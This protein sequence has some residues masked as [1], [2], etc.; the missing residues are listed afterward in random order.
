[1]QSYRLEVAVKRVY[2]L[3]PLI[4]SASST[5][6]VEVRFLDFPPIVIHPHGYAIG[7]SVTYNICHKADFRM[8]SEQA[9]TAFPA[10]CQCQLVSAKEGTVVGAARW[11]CPC[12]LVSQPD[13]AAQPPLRT[14]ADY[15]IGNAAGETVGYADMNCRVLSL[16]APAPQASV[17]PLPVAAPPARDPE[18][19]RGTSAD[20]G[21]PY[22]VRV[23]VGESDRHRRPSQ[24]TRCEGV[25]DASRG[26]EVTAARA[27]TSD[28]G[29]PPR[30]VPANTAEKSSLLYLLQ[31]DVAYQLQSLSETVAAALH[32][33][34]DVLTRT[35]LKGPDK[36]GTVSTSRLTKSI[37]HHV[38][39]IV[40]VANI[41]LQVANQLVDNSPAPPRIGTSREVKDMVRQWRNPVNKLPLPAEGSIGHYLQYDV[42]YQLQCLGTNL[43]YMIVAYRAAL[44]I[45]LSS[46]PAQHVEYCDEL[47]HEIQHLTKHINILIQSS[48]D[49]TLSTAAPSIVPEPVAQDKHRKRSKRNSQSTPPAAGP[50]LAPPKFTGVAKSLSRT[51]YSSFS[52][53]RSASS[54][55][56]SS[57]SSSSSLN[58]PPARASP[59]QA[60]TVVAVPAN[61]PPAVP[62]PQAAAPMPNATS[63]PVPPPPSYN[64]PAAT[65]SSPQTSPPLATPPP[66]PYTVAAPSAQPT[67]TPLPTPAKS[68]TGLSPSNSIESFSA[69]TASSQANQPVPP[70]PWI[71]QENNYPP[72]PVATSPLSFHTELQSTGMYG[73]ASS[74]LAPQPVL[75]TGGP[76]VLSPPYLSSVPP[77]LAAPTPLTSPSAAPSP[78]PLVAPQLNTQLP[79]QP[80]PQAPL[81]IP[82]PVPIPR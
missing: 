75:A 22:I 67:A 80:Q 24:P 46:I 78:Q 26:R 7:D 17:T 45:P 28:R 72:P 3:N 50:Q 52:S 51:S 54:S 58:R 44:D 68:Q 31:Y 66:P 82:I 13:A 32:R 15:V 63:Q 48:V 29:Q 77:P 5:I 61:P 19:S 73:T 57:S 65:A 30:R 39:S 47:G 11:S 62:S 53:T 69:P 1:M 8:S 12:P 16:D 81:A 56:L 27:S 37:D 36:S 4:A 10:M 74:T 34:H 18:P 49:G 38:A 14:Y 21:K 55:S 40:R 41:V 79:I 23:V 33:E 59:P 42:L 20:Q 25:Q 6:S 35:P 76:P 64:A 60:P 70:V 71:N 43:S 2:G 9:A